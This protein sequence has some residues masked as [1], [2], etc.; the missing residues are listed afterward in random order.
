MGDKKKK[1]LDK[2]QRRLCDL[3]TGSAKEGFSLSGC[4]GAEGMFGGLGRDVNYGFREKE[5]C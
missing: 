5:V 1:K 3:V 4:R 2:T